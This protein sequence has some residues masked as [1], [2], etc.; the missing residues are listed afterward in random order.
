MWADIT[1]G[2]GRHSGDVGRCSFD[3]GQSETAPLVVASGPGWIRL[4]PLLFHPHHLRAKR[5]PVA[6]R[7]R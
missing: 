4:L 1:L 7:Y 2:L 5:F 6:F 3:A